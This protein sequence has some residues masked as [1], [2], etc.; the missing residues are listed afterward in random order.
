MQDKGTQYYSL[1]F[2]INAQYAIKNAE[3]IRM[4]G[5][6]S[7]KIY[8]SR[9]AGISYSFSPICSFHKRRA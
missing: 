7:E 4:N 6:K 1:S 3:N 8:L 5:M 2:G 9:F